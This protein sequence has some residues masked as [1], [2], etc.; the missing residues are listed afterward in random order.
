MSDED[1]TYSVVRVAVLDFI[2]GVTNSHSEIHFGNWH[3][4][5][6]VYVCTKISKCQKFRNKIL[7]IQIYSLYMHKVV[8][9]KSRHF[10]GD[11]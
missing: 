4:F 9:V 1:R 5:R 10:L 3:P 11:V 7:R 8:F 2:Y 6:E